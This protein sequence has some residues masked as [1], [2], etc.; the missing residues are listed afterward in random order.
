[1]THPLTV[2]AEQADMRLDAF[3]ARMLPGCTARGAKRLIERG[4]VRVGGRNRPAH[5]R[6]RPG[7]MVEISPAA[8]ASE[9]ARAEAAAGES[10]PLPKILSAVRLL[11]ATAEYAVFTKPAGLHTARISGSAALSL[12]EALAGIWP[13]LWAS[14]RPNEADP[15]APALL[16]R[17]DSPTSGLV[18]AAFSLDAATAFRRL[19]AAGLVEKE[20][21]AVVYG[22]LTEPLLL[23]KTLDT[24]GRSKTR[25][26]TKDNPDPTR[27]TSVEPLG[28]APLPVMPEDAVA[29]ATLVSVRIRRGAR[30]QIRAH[31]A[32]AGLPIAG[33]NLYGP[34]GSSDPPGGALYLHH[35][36][37]ALPQ[38]SVNS[39]P[40]WAALLPAAP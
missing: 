20:Y 27:H 13:G 17:L 18:L 31:L 5:F 30:H 12:E 29:E 16:T 35:S 28:P 40:E 9:N 11:A 22:R 34:A 1:M 14:L 26:L 21:H 4:L 19:E 7:N 6:L 32:D 15:P 33:D 25:V 3:L 24:A 37:L 39:P 10:A 8:A 23:R 36:R 2:L 38:L